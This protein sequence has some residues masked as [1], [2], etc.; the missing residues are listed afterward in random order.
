MNRV[1]LMGL[2]VLLAACLYAL[3]ELG[4][5]QHITGARSGGLTREAPPTCVEVEPLAGLPECVR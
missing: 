3:G 1:L 2:V 5:V 4:E